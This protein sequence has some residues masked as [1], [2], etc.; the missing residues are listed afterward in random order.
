MKK[1]FTLIE[2]LVVI[3]IIA[4]LAS[5]LLPALSKAREK[6]RS[7]S[8]INNLKQ[9]GISFS[10]YFN[11]SEDYLPP[12]ESGAGFASPTWTQY[13][14][15]PNKNNATNYWATDGQSTGAYVESKMFKCPSVKGDWRPT[16]HMVQT[17]V[18]APH[19]AVLQTIFIRAATGLIGRKVTGIRN[20]SQK[21]LLVDI[22]A[23]DSNGLPQQSGYLRW[24]P[25]QTPGPSW[26]IPAGR[27]SNGC[28]TLY[29]DMHAQQHNV[30]D[31]NHSMSFAPYQKDFEDGIHW[32]YEQ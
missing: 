9:L 4:I 13:L 32:K 2:L 31:P 19:Y 15:G 10:M 30:K 20:V 1:S 12:M 5:M 24:S 25:E 16:T 28:N 22:A 7:T 29:F 17:W 6:A 21:F 26:P 14:M 27:H 11:D 3:A 23:C 18:N 8:C